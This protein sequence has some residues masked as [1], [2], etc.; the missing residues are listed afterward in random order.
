MISVCDGATG[1]ANELLYWWPVFVIEAG[2]VYRW[3]A[4]E[5]KPVIYF[6]PKFMA[7]GL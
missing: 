7:L 4:S 1:T 6:P 5:N 2:S 3:E